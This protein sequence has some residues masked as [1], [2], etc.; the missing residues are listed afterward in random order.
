MPRPTSSRRDAEADRKQAIQVGDA[1]AALLLPIV[2]LAV[3]RRLGSHLFVHAVKRA[4]VRAAIDETFPGDLKVNYSRLAV[5]T[6]LTRKEVSLLVGGIKGNG[7]LPGS[8]SREQRALRVVRGWRVDPRF[9]D[10]RGRPAPL[11]LRSPPWLRS[12]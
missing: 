2:A 12:L 11:A 7:Q 5:I 4:Y 1:L 9:H 3:R 10:D 8:D 6:G